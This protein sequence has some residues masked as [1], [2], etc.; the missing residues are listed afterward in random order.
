M[1][2]KYLLHRWQLSQNTRS[3]SLIAGVRWVN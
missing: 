1:F 2:T 3:S